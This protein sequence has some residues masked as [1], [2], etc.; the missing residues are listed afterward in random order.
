MQA[1]GA[2]ELILD[3]K[4]ARFERGRCSLRIASLFRVLVRSERLRTKR[5]DGSGSI[6]P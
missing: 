1:F 3:A 5:H 6:K 2:L 4:D